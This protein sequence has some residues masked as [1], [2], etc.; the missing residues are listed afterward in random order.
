MIRLFPAASVCEWCGSP[1]PVT[2]LCQARPG[3]TRRSFLFVA[4][5]AAVALAVAPSLGLERS[6]KSWY[7]RFDPRDPPL[8]ELERWMRDYNRV[9]SE[10][11]AHL[12]VMTVPLMRIA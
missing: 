6:A 10:L 1:H 3:F 12:R 9:R 11:V 7:P 2:A 8:H 4:G 5:A